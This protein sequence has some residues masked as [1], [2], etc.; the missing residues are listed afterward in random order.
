MI[1]N[2]T[3]LQK[4]PNDTGDCTVFN[5]KLSTYHKACI[6]TTMNHYD[7]CFFPSYSNNKTLHRLLMCSNHSRII[8]ISRDVHADSSMAFQLLKR[9]LFLSFTTYYCYQTC[10]YSLLSL[11]TLIIFATF[12]IRTNSSQSQLI[13]NPSLDLK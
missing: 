12:I 4:R 5:N 1:A 11:F 3:T 9:L 2:V 6:W 7:P 10:S 13:H 8:L